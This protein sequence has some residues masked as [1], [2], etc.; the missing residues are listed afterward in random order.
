MSTE[1]EFQAITRFFAKILHEFNKI[2]KR[3]SD[4]RKSATDVFTFHYQFLAL[5]R[6]SNILQLKYS[7]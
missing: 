7:K 4:I 3:V 2:K 6:M 5:Y 1:R